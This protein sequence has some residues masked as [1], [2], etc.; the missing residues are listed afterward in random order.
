[1]CGIFSVHGQA[2]ATV[3]ASMLKK[4]ISVPQDVDPRSRYHI[5]GRDTCEHHY[6]PSGNTAV[7]RE[8]TCLNCDRICGF[9]KWD[10]K[11]H[12]L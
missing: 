3:S 9:Y 10:E 5:G 1:V 12:S 2:G 6:V 11:G 4:L 8:W 7:K